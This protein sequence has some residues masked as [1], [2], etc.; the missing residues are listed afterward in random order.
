MNVNIF[1]IIFFYSG[2]HIEDSSQECEL[3]LVKDYLRLPCLKSILGYYYMCHEKHIVKAM[4]HTSRYSGMQTGE[5][6]KK[7]LIT[8]E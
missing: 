3:Y 6:D 7:S 4:W 2:T 8:A 5:L 1:L